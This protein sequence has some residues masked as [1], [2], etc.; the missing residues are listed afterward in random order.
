MLRYCALTLK[1]QA[2][3][4]KVPLRTDYV[5]GQMEVGNFAGLKTLKGVS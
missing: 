1:G 2:S 5:A 4:P 3:P